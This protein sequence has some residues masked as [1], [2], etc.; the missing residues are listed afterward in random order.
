VGRARVLREDREL[1]VFAPLTARALGE[2]VDVAF[3]AA[4]RTERFKVEVTSGDAAFDRVRFRERIPRAQADLGTGILT[5]SF[6]G[7]D[8]TR[9]QEVRLRAAR[10]RA[11]LEVEEISL[12]GDRLSASGEIASRARGVVRLELSY[13]DVQGRAQVFGTNVAIDDGDWSVDDVQVPPEIASN[14]AYVSVL[15][16]GY[17]ERRIRGEMISYEIEPGQ[18]RRP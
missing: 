16:T 12:Q 15:F 7:N 14:G 6:A 2:E 18:T 11:D 5:L 4:G 8:V 17:F 10:N 3:R 1:D 13:L 9:P